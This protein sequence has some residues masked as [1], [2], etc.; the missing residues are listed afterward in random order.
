MKF[1]LDHDLNDAVAERFVDTAMKRSC[2]AMFSRR[3]RPIRKS[4]RLLRR[5]PA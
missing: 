5:K 1:F 4:S 3:T 2:S